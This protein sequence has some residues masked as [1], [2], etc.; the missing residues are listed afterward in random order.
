[1]AKFTIYP[2]Y[3]GDNDHDISYFVLKAE[4][5]IIRK[6]SLGCIAIRNND[7]GE[8][9]L[10]DTGYPTKEEI[11]ENALPYNYVLEVDGYRTLV[12]ALAEADIKAEEV[13]RICLS[14]LHSDHAWNL[15]LFRKDIPIYVQRKEVEHA[16]APWKV[17]RNSY[18]VID[19]PGCPG[20]MRGIEQF[21]LQD[22]D[23]EIEP[24]LN[25]LFTPGHTCG[26][27]S[28]LVDTE[29]GK[30]IYVGDLYYAEENWINSVPTG[31]YYSMDMWYRSNEKVLGIGAKILSVHVK[32]TFDKKVYG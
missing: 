9:T 4:P 15:Q 13:T 5:G 10:L 27:Q 24:G 1:M 14:H 30:Y 18:Q 16:I 23:Y 6:M 12:D 17:E 31:W 29:D 22:G 25:A 28:F 26:S 2:I 19:K 32:S 20:W 8:V 11:I 7:T 21:V 3:M